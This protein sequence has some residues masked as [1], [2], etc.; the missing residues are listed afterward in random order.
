[1]QIISRLLV[2][3][4]MILCHFNGAMFS[5]WTDAILYLCI[6]T[7]SIGAVIVFFKNNLTLRYS[8][9]ELIFLLYI[10]YLLVFNGIK[11]SLLNNERLLTYLTILFLYLPLSILYK[12]DKGLLR[13]ILYGILATATLEV[14]FGFGQIFGF[15][16][17]FNSQF[18][19]GGLFGNPGAFGGHLAIVFS[20]IFVMVMFR[21]EL[22]LSENIYYAS[23]V[24]LLC[25][26]FLVIMSDSRGAW[27][28]TFSGLAFI[29]NY[30]YNIISSATSFLKSKTVIYISGVVLICF[31]VILSF[32]LYQY[33]PAS[34]FGRLFVWKVSKEMVLEK[35]IFGNGYGFFEASYGK[36][37]AQYFIDN[38]AGS[39]EIEVADYVTCAYNEFL[40]MLIESG[41][42]G[43]VLFLGILF[44]AFFSRSNPNNSKIRIA[45]KAS[46]IAL[47]A[48]SMV[49]YPFRLMPNQ[50]ILVS[51]IF[52]IFQTANYK[53]YHTGHFAKTIA[54]LMLSI[55]LVLSFFYG[56]YLYGTYHFRNGYAKVIRGD[57]NGGIKDYVIAANQL[58]NNGKFLFYFGSAF[59]L[60]QDYE[61]SVD[62]LKKAAELTSNPNAFIT[63]GNSFKELKRYEE[64]EQA[65]KTASGI[66][67]AKLYPRYL[68]VLL[69]IEMQET[70]KALIM[71]NYIINAEEKIATTAGRQIKEEMQ[72]LVD[73]YSKPDV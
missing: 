58:Q 20:F 57:I 25:V 6:V 21:K 49:S 36:I 26:V 63:L 41:F 10:T 42:V 52:I 8:I 71:A 61:Q 9:P 11:G 48:L 69:Y 73:Q 44:F 54:L 64:A 4:I 34:A 12:R 30:K 31:I 19:L 16:P 27:I 50:I 24:C 62:F 67:P 3:L 53:T 45:A 28:A 14:V 51:C 47:I 65:Y 1:M 33:K 13:Y 5:V 17:N 46:L 32:A 40:E 55:I 39:N 22:H 60:K 66:T 43:L 38:N 29:L 15:I 35:P 18:V 7:I 56:K 70:E 68:L 23:L 2:M 72:I 37:Q 59:Y